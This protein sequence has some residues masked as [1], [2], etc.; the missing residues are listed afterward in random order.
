MFVGERRW[1]CFLCVVGGGGGD[2][3]TCNNLEVPV[4]DEVVVE[5]AKR[6]YNLSR[7]ELTHTKQHRRKTA[8]ETQTLDTRYTHREHSMKYVDKCSRRI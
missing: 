6:A 4:D 1:R 8:T 5:V 7:K 2:G 3:G